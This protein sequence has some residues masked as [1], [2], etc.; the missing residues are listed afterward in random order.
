MEGLKFRVVTAEYEKHQTTTDEVIVLKPRAFFQRYV[1]LYRGRAC[2]QILDL[3]VWEGG[4]ALLLAAIFAPE[5]LVGVDISAP[6]PGFDAVR[7]S[8]PLGRRI[9]IHY[10]TSQD[11][12]AKL[13]AIIASEF[14]GPIDLIIDDASHLYAPTRRAF[15]I[16]FPHLR[17]GGFYVIEDWGWAHWAGSWQTTSLWRDQPAMSNFVFELS[18]ACAAR[19]RLIESVTVTSEYA[20]VRKGMKAPIGEPLRLDAIC[21]RQ[22]REFRPI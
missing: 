4:S 12:E 9:S 19:P 8:H 3:G 16:A 1:N 2:R 17:P 7:A 5:K 20:I 6:R 13:A 10:E 21:L 15:E 11:D 22:G 18:M 14:E